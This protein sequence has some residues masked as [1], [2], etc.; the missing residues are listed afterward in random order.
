MARMLLSCL[1]ILA[2]HLNLN[3]G[4]S[5][6]DFSRLGSWVLPVKRERGSSFRQGSLRRPEE[7]NGSSEMLARVCHI[8]S[9]CYRR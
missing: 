8:Y 6:A 7:T 4:Y 1:T 3:R 2:S 5:V 9:T